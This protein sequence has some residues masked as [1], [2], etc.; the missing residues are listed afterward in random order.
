MD[1][2]KAIEFLVEEPENKSK[3]RLKM[4]GDFSDSTGL[5]W[6][7]ENS[8]K[9]II[10]RIDESDVMWSNGLQWLSIIH[11]HVSSYT[12]MRYT[13]EY[14]YTEQYE[15]KYVTRTSSKPPREL[16]REIREQY[17]TWE[18]CTYCV[19]Y[20]GV[21]DFNGMYVPAETRLEIVSISENGEYAT[22]S[23]GY[24]FSKIDLIDGDIVK[25]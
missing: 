21:V 25:N 13:I 24:T 4:E 8:I 11:D 14:S 18:K 6:Y 17:A 10:L 3:S 1:V 16:M 19:V 5:R 15:V 7:T 9:H 23:D 12:D 2:I 20:E 22:S